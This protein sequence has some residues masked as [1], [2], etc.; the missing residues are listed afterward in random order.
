MHLTPRRGNGE[1]LNSD[2]DAGAVGVVSGFALC[3]R[4]QLELQMSVSLQL[5]SLAL[6][7]TEAESNPF[8]AEQNKLLNQPLKRKVLLKIAGCGVEIFDSYFP[9]WK[10]LARFLCCAAEWPEYTDS[11]VLSGVGFFTH[12]TVLFLIGKT[13]LLA[14]K[15]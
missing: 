1:G 9:P 11:S 6:V 7:R 5:S 15:S 13:V 10:L 4:V 2:V 14:F 12:L 3:E 8:I